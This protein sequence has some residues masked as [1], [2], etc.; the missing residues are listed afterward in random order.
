MRLLSKCLDELSMSLDEASDYVYHIWSAILLEKIVI[1]AGELF[2]EM[3]DLQLCYY[4][5][6]SYSDQPDLI[7]VTMPPTTGYTTNTRDERAS[8]TPS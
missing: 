8:R 6:K 3:L 2:D 7:T 5:Y 1:R 4:K